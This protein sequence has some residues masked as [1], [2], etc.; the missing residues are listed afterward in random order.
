MVTVYLSIIYVYIYCRNINSTI[1]L[2]TFLKSYYSYNFRRIT[3]EKISNTIF[4]FKLPERM[5][6]KG[7]QVR[8]WKI[9]YLD[10]DLRIMRAGRP[11]N[12]ESEYFLFILRRN[13]ESRFKVD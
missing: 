8:I 4:G 13:E 12:V 2:F 3:F 1:Y 10:D 11:D 5:F 7:E 6:P 9:T